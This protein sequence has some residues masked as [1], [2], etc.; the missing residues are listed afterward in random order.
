M[1]LSMVGGLAARD[2]TWPPRS[3]WSL[4][5][6]PVSPSSLVWVVCAACHCPSD[7]AG[8]LRPQPWG[9]GLPGSQVSVGLDRGAGAVYG[10][11]PA[12]VFVPSSAVQRSPPS[13][14][15]SADVAGGQPRVGHETRWRSSLRD[16][17]GL[18]DLREG[19]QVTRM[20]L[21]LATASGI[22]MMVMACAA[23]VVG[24]RWPAQSPARRTE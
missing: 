3:I 20:S 15:W 24:G 10:L 21:M 22:T 4:C 11:V 18:D 23:A 12:V 14:S 5:Q 2:S 13:S 17:A 16:L 6:S 7:G 8:L 19:K 1:G 9:P